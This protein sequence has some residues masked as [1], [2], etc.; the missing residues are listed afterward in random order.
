MQSRIKYLSNN[1]NYHTV[2]LIENLKNINYEDIPI[3]IICYNNGFMVKDTVEALQSKFKNPLIVINNAS[4][5]PGTKLILDELKK[6]GIKIS[7]QENNKGH[8]IINEIEILHK[9][10]Y[11]IITD[12]D[13]EL[14]NLP[15]NT[16]KILHDLSKCFDKSRK[17]GLALRIDEVNDIINNEIVEWE[18]Q[19]WNN[20]IQYDN[21]EIY[22]ADIDTT[23][24]LQSPI[25]K[26]YHKYEDNNIRLAGDYT[27]RHLPWHKSYIQK[28]KKENYEEYFND[29]NKSSSYQGI[30]QKFWK[31]NRE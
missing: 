31:L 29:K 28:M 11:F 18:K 14:Q 15:K 7:D 13:L 21:Y 20:R 19:F 5:S 2:K 6:Q 24:H 27:I 26:M 3:Y 1:H 30:I 17:I 12:P 25:P 10:S 23:F 4:N 9:D 16:I 22:N 8:K